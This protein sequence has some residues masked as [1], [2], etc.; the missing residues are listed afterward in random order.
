M[1]QEKMRFKGLPYNKVN[2][3]A[4]SAFYGCVCGLFLGIFPAQAQLFDWFS[5]KNIEEAATPAQNTESQAET[6]DVVEKP[7]TKAKKPEK[8]DKNKKK[9]EESQKQDDNKPREDKVF[10]QNISWIAHRINERALSGDTPSLMLDSTYRI[11][12]FGGCNTFSAT[13]YPLREQGFAVGP[14]ATTKKACDKGIMELEKNF[15]LTLRTAQ[16]WDVVEGALLI[17][18]PRGTLKFDRS[19]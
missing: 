6:A 16:T 7:K 8:Q 9:T 4:K 18:S 14:I 5:S 2:R 19:F 12:G 1:W 11:R 15:L 17:K 3:A 13:A 10:P